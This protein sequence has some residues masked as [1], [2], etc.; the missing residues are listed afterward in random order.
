MSDRYELVETTYDG[1]REVHI[2]NVSWVLA[3][4]LK[5]ILAE[6]CAGRLT[7]EDVIEGSD[8]LCSDDL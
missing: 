5:D 4:A 6:R 8:D 1:K 2:S 7:V 3:E